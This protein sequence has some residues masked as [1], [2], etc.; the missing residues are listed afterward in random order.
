MLPS[1]A[2]HAQCRRTKH[3]QHISTMTLVDL[4]RILP[5]HHIFH[6][7]QA[8]FNLPMPGF[9]GCNLRSGADGGGKVYFL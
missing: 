2:Q 4:T 1:L 9:Q 5:E 7:M 6:V 8:V 3:C